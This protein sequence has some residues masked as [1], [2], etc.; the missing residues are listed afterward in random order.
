[1]Q[2][3]QER[4]RRVVQTELS[5]L[6]KKGISRPEAVKILLK[7]IVVEDYHPSEA[8]VCSVSQKFQ[9]GAEDATRALIV[10]HEVAYKMSWVG[11]LWGNS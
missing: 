2:E 11:I 5:A 4:F 10:K 3:A 6:L 7:R 1:M 9:L 8:E